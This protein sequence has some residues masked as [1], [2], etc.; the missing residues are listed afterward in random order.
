[1]RTYQQ[2]QNYRN[3]EFPQT[4]D[5][6]L[7]FSLSRLQPA[8]AQLWQ[9]LKDSVVSTF[10]NE[11]RIWEISDAAGNFA[12]KIYDPMNDETL[13]LDSEQEVLSWLEQYRKQPRRSW[14][15]RF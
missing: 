1:M 6:E 13:Q 15:S 4:N 3:L 11:P 12:W 2:Q 5:P 14:D 7:Q 10:S 8:L 9:F